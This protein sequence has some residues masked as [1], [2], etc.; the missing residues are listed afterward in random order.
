MA[1]RT[2]KRKRKPAQSFRVKFEH[3]WNYTHPSRS[4]SRYPN[5]W[6]GRVPRAIGEAAVK[7]GAARR[8][9]T[10]STTT[11]PPVG[12][13]GGKLDNAKPAPTLPGNLSPD[14]AEPQALTPNLHISDDSE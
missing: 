3:E 12:P 8:V 11:T 10:A 6:E 1:K 13:E 2:T 7:A 5:N 4:M 14:L 9:G